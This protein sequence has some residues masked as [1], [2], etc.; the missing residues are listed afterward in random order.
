MY[1]LVNVSVSGGGKIQLIEIFIFDIYEQILFL[2]LE[3]GKKK[4]YHGIR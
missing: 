2:R 3:V 1:Y 4:I